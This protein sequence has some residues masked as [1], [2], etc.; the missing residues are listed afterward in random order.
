MSEREQIQVIISPDGE[1]SIE[2]LGFT[3]NTC[4]SATKPFEDGLGI[5][6][7]QR[8]KPEFYQ[9]QVQPQTKNR[10]T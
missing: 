1:V 7:Q 6:K 9:T 4:T 3:D 8:N 5:V 10:Q 2:A